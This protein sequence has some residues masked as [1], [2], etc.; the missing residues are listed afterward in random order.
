MKYKKLKD[1]QEKIKKE[2]ISKRKL[3][4]QKKKDEFKKLSK[5][6][7]KKII[8]EKNKY[9][10]F[11]YFDKFNKEQTEELMKAKLVYVDPGK[12]CIYYMVDDNDT[13]F[14][15][16]NKMRINEIKRLKYQKLR[17]K[18]KK[19]KMIEIETELSNF[20]SKSCDY[21]KFK[22]YIKKKN[23]INNKLFYFYEQDYFRK[24]NWFS[25]INTKRSEDNLLNKIEKVYGKN[26]KI[27]MGDWNESGSSKINYM[28]TPGISLK[29]KLSERF[30]VYNLDEFRTS[31]LNYKTEER[32]ENLYLPDKKGKS[33]KIHAILTY[34]MENKRKGC[35][36]RDKN[37]VL[38]MKK[39]VQHYLKNRERPQN[40]RREVKIEKISKKKSSKN[41]NRCQPL[42]SSRILNVK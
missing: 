27:I 33:R 26:I 20:N 42:K 38:N 17:E 7:K 24:L 21:G 23:E 29:R 30:E 6:E 36:N 41:K 39:I 13:Y 3:E 10:E 25:Y 32:C 8:D 40:Y 9:I 18:K 16:T 19:N 12:R 11:P 31:C 4:L 5:K 15:Y 1:E 35:I 37:S 2:N 34:Q 14:K 22:E 28:S